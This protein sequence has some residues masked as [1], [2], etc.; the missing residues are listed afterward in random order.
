[1]IGPTASRFLPEPGC[2]GN[3]VPW[4]WKWVQRYWSSIMMWSESAQSES[5]DELWLQRHQA[6]KLTITAV[7]SSWL[8]E[9]KDMRKQRTVKVYIWRT[10]LFQND[11]I[12]CLN[13]L[14]FYLAF[15][16]VF[17]VI[18]FFF[19]CMST[20]YPSVFSLLVFWPKQWALNTD[21][22]ALSIHFHSAYISLATSVHG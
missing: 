20:D 14:F 17:L 9:M 22:N 15:C 19:W 6:W 8:K 13:S 4:Q 12:V 3:S 16:D 21:T 2:W 18:M 5:S 10:K 1:M 7:L 11:K